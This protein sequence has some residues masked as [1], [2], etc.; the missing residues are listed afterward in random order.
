MVRRNRESMRAV[1]RG[2]WC[3]YCLRQLSDYGEQYRVFK[4]SGVE[5]VAVSSE[6]PRRSRRMRTG[7]KLPFAVLSD[8]KL[9]V[10]K[11]LGLIGHEK[12]GEPTPATL[13]LDREGV[14]L[15]TL[16]QWEKSLLARDVLE[17]VRGSMRA[18]AA[19]PVPTPQVA[20]PRP[21]I[22]FAKAVTNMVAGLVIR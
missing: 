19:E 15:S 7:L 20:K 8:T 16:N 10:A 1:A 9:E 22:L 2:A 14:K 21:G 11:H 18:V 3:P 13:V 12:P 4:E 6:S 5:V 17:F